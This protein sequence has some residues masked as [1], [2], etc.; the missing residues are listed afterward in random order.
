MDKSILL[1]HL[2]A[3]ITAEE[4]RKLRDRE[5]PRISEHNRK[6]LLEMMDRKEPVFGDT[7]ANQVRTLCR[8]LEDYLVRYLSG[9]ESDWKWI[10]LSCIYLSFICGLPLHA[11]DAAHYTVTEEHGT[12]TYHCPMKS[13]EPDT[14]C[15]FC[16]CKPMV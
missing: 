16:V 12:R 3:A 9:K 8:I 7:D 6:T 5:I 11:M 2:Q 13:T 4:I 1:N 14:A 15:A 10:I